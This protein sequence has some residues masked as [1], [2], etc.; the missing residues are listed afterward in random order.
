[1]HGHAGRFLFS[2]TEIAE[3]LMPLGKSASDRPTCVP[4]YRNMR[5]RNN[6]TDR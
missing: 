5:V 4:H 1:M 6:V 2:G 3:P